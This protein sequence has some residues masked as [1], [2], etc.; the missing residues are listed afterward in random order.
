MK[1]LC[2]GGDLQ[3]ASGGQVSV[4]DF[5]IDQHAETLGITR[6]AHFL[7][8]FIQNIACPVTIAIKKK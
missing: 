1:I 7:P 3:L 5:N 4:C 2:F 8:L 6:V